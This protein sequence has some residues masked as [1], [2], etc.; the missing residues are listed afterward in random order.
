VVEMLRAFGANEWQ[1]FWRARL[2]SALPQIFTGLDVAV[3]LSVGGAVVGEFVGAKGGLGFQ[4]LQANFTFD[5]PQL[6]AVLIGLGAMGVSGHVIIR[7]LQRRV[8]FWH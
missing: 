4:T 3:V 8:V 5:I 6:F 7:Q 2:K 1:V